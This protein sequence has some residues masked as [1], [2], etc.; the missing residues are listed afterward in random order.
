[1]YQLIFRHSSKSRD[2]RKQLLELFCA[3]IVN[4]M[5]L[6]ISWLTG[7]L[8]IIFTPFITNSVS[9]ITKNALNGLEHTLVVIVSRVG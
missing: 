5:L 6:Q 8:Y 7:G 3:A 9:A 1:M 2:G 4:T